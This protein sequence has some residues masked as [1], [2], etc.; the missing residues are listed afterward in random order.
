MLRKVLNTYLITCLM[1]NHRK[2]YLLL[3]IDYIRGQTSFL[4]GSSFT[5]F[6]DVFRVA[7]AGAIFIW[8]FRYAVDGLQIIIEHFVSVKFIIVISVLYLDFIEVSGLLLLKTTCFRLCHW[9]GSW[10]AFTI[11]LLFRRVLLLVSE[12][13]WP[14]RSLTVFLALRCRSSLCWCLR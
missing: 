8:N 13:S 5:W 12:Y 7:L 10:V 9:I 6:C 1:L 3:S 11:Q 14:Q 2:L 4:I